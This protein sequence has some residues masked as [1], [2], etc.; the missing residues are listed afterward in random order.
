M[1]IYIYN[2]FQSPLMSNVKKEVV[3]KKSGSGGSTRSNSTL[4]SKEVD[5][6]NWKR[7]KSYDPMKAAAEGK[8][9][10]AAK[11]QPPSVMTQSIHSTMNTPKR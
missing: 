5:F 3:K 1:F 7:R 9:K 2:F 11:K 6:Q 10:D 8:K 4:S